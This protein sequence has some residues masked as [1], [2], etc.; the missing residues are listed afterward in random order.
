MSITIERP[1]QIEKSIQFRLG[2]TFTELVFWNDV[3]KINT[4]N[5]HYGNL[6]RPFMHRPSIDHL[7]PES[8]TST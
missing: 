8:D 4:S 3:Y 5:H 7:A 1:N 6:R 2:R